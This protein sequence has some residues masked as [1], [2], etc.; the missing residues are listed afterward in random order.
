LVACDLERDQTITLDEFL[1]PG[2]VGE[3]IVSHF[4]TELDIDLEM[5]ETESLNVE[6]HQA[7]PSNELHIRCSKCQQVRVI[8]RPPGLPPPSLPHFLTFSSRPFLFPS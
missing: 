6:Q 7:S 2:G 4:G 8:K 3:S 5:I 1:L